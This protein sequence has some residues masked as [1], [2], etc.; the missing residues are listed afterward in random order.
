MCCGHFELNGFNYNKTIV[1]KHGHEPEIF[2]NFDLVLSGHFHIKSSKDNIHYVG[3]PIQTTWNDYGV[4]KGFHI[5]DTYDGK[6][7]FI[8]NDYDIFHIST[9][10]FTGTKGPS[11]NPEKQPQIIIPPPPNFT[12]GTVHSSRYCSPD[13]H[14]TQIHPSDNEA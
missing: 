7:S 9:L 13:I 3:N 12:L 2:K 8:K 6:L 5:Y 4:E 14:L 11:T 1:S 10:L